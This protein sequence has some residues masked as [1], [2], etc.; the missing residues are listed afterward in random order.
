M[1]H[2]IF[3]TV[4]FSGLTIQNGDELGDGGG[5]LNEGTLTLTDVIVTNNTN[6]GFGGGISNG[7]ILNLVDS[8][9]SGNT[10][11]FGVHNAI[12]GFLSE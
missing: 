1:F 7:S 6:S 12:N 8:S 9:V 3:G 10:D 2:I 5:I 11:N 4:E